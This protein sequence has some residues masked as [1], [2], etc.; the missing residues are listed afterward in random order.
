MTTFPSV[1]S[2]CIVLSSA[3]KVSGS[4]TDFLINLK[5][6]LPPQ[7]KEY[8]VRMSAMTVGISDSSADIIDLISV[9]VSSLGIPQTIVSNANLASDMLGT[10][11]FGTKRS[12]SNSPWLRCSNPN[13]GQ[14]NVK[15]RKVSTGALATP[16]TGTIDTVCLAMEFVPITYSKIARE[17]ESYKQ[18][19]F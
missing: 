9:H 12:F 2:I 19:G 10:F 13:I 4:P 17:K 18:P 3:D 5:G 15:L 16:T 6:R 11:N 1:E 14:V 8:Y 7:V